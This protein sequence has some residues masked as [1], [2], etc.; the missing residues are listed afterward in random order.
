[1]LFKFPHVELIDFGFELLAEPEFTL[2]GAIISNDTIATTTTSTTT[3][4]PAA[5]AVPTPAG[6]T[7]AP[8]P[9]NTD[10]PV[11]IVPKLYFGTEFTRYEY[12]DYESKMPR[13]IKEDLD[14]RKSF[15]T[16]IWEE[17]CGCP[18]VATTQDPEDVTRPSY[19]V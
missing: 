5:G 13:H 18:G 19:Q 16:L 11:L 14:K 9:N 4:A 17:R 7:S 12:G 1:M 2:F 15:D 3:A 8:T 6:V 10:T